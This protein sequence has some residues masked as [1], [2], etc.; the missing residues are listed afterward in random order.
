MRRFQFRLERLLWHRHLLE[1]LAEQAL[2]TALQAEREVADDL[3]Q[4][5][6]QAAAEAVRLREV[7]TRSTLGPE[8]I[9]HARFTASLRA[10]Q[11]RLLQRQ[12]EAMTVS[13]ERRVALLERR[14]AREVV[15]KLRERALSRYRQEAAREDQRVLD[16]TASVRH[17]SGTMAQGL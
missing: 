16:E 15:L 9:L 8:L 14:R 4:A 17:A 11:D 6:D 7:L 3:A 10:R 12:Q 2:A 13:D 1:E 5:R